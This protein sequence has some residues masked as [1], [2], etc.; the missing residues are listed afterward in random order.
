M[1]IYTLF[2]ANDN[3]GFLPICCTYLF[4]YVNI[5]FLTLCSARWCTSVCGA[6]QDTNNIHWWW[7]L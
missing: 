4:V 6:L 3:V 7:F 1:W 5:F 2:N